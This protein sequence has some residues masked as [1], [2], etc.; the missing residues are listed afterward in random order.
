MIAAPTMERPQDISKTDNVYQAMK[1]VLEK[2]LLYNQYQ[3]NNQGE[4]IS[5]ILIPGMG[6]GIG[7]MGYLES[8][9]QMRK[10]FDDVQSDPERNISLDYLL[11]GTSIHLN[12]YFSNL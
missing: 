11:R 8:A 2:T 9:R 1:A 10:G 5:S 3:K 4:L 12:E 7:G 6:T